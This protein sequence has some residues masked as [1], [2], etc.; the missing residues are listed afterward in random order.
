[1]NKDGD[2]KLYATLPEW[3]KVRRSRDVTADVATDRGPLESELV[4]GVLELIRGEF[5][6]LQCNGRECDEAAR[7]HSAEIRQ[8][9]ILYANDS[10]SQLSICCIPP[11]L[12]SAE[13]GCID[14]P[15]IKNA[16]TI[17]GQECRAADVSL[18]G[19]TPN[20]IL[21]C[22]DEGMV[23]EIDDLDSAPVDNDLT[24]SL[25]ERRLRKN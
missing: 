12:V 10:L 16:N 21:D 4:D 23:V 13:H 22:P 11:V 18:Q 20:D 3:V 9:L 25:S 5:R 6:V 17:G 8:T 19:C 14:A 1:M 15:L 2:A 24:A 7:E